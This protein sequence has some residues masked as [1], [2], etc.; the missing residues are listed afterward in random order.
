[1]REKKE[2][3]NMKVQDT[4]ERRISAGKKSFYSK[5]DKIYTRETR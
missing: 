1:M 5:K 4:E 2:S 3:D